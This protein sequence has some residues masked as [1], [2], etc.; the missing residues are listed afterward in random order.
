MS[1]TIT[2]K[3]LSKKDFE[4]DQDVRWCPGCGDYAILAQVQKVLPSLGIPRENFLMVLLQLI[5]MAVSYTHL[6]LPT[7]A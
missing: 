7:K 4:T 2:Q 3:P 5:K 1:D 6:T